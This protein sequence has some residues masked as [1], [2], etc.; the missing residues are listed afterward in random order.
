MYFWISSQGRVCGGSRM[1]GRYSIFIDQQLT[2]NRCRR[3]RRI[4]NRYGS[5]RF[6]YYRGAVYGDRRSEETSRRWDA[7]EWEGE[8][9]RRVAKRLDAWP[10][11]EKK[12]SQTFGELT[13]GPSLSR[14]HEGESSFHCNSGASTISA[15][16]RSIYLCQSLNL[17]LISDKLAVCSLDKGKYQCFALCQAHLT[18]KN[19]LPAVLLCAAGEMAFSSDASYRGSFKCNKFHG[20]GRYEWNDGATYEGGWRENK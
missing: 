18:C 7:R 16:C 10:R 13:F 20:F 17:P 11:F 14:R 9:R 2:T 1:Y 8:V 4:Y 3:H 15:H 6:S 12:S 5:V 19:N